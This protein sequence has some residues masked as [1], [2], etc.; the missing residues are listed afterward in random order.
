MKIQFSSNQQYQLDG[1]RSVVDLFDGQPL[2]GGPFEFRFE[3]LTGLGFTELG[4]GNKLDLAPPSMLENLKV[5]QHRNEIPE[6]AALEAMDFT[7]EMETGTGKTYV[8]LRTLY[9]LNARYGFTKFVIVV[10]SVAI[11]EGVLSS[12]RL[13][14]EHFQTVYGNVPVDAWVY[15]SAQVSRLRQFAGSNQMQILVMNIQA[16]DKK[17]ISIIQKDLDGMSGRKPIEFIQS[18]RP[19][20]VID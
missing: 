8:Y 1:I 20:V 11:R 7:V 15:D 14:K 9:E 3:S 16:F 6:S 4:C 13:T 17:D 18:T 12:I 19:I 2:A 5:V 10:P